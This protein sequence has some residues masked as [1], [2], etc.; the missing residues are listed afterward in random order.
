MAGPSQRSA[1]SPPPSVKGGCP[2]NTPQFHFTPIFCMPGKPSERSV[3]QPCQRRQCEQ[4]LDECIQH[5]RGREVRLVFFFPDTLWMAFK[6][7]EA[8]RNTSASSRTLPTLLLDPL[9]QIFAQLGL[10]GF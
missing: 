10:G 3:A 4:L 5:H 2:P 9:L 8:T 6:E 1:S 7:R